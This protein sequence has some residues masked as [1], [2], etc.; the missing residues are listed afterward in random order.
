MGK[1]NRSAR[2]LLWEGA[3]CTLRLPTK[4]KADLSA[5]TAQPRPRPS[6][7]HGAG[8]QALVLRSFQ[9]DWVSL[10]AKQTAPGV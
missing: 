5:C 9:S 8:R 3:Y 4:A 6:P 7:R 10:E 1:R 2:A